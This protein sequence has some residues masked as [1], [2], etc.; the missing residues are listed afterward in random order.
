MDD[1]N[2]V[3]DN[4]QIEIYQ[5]NGSKGVAVGEEPPTAPPGAVIKKYEYASLPQKYSKKYQYAARFVTLVRSRT[6]KVTM[7]TREAKCM[8]MENSPT[9]DFEAVFYNGKI[10]V[11]HI[12]LLVILRMI[13]F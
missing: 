11:T 1:L 12:S 6:P 9:P 8:L 2:I 7:Y 10:S 13:L 5:P 4:V 3:F